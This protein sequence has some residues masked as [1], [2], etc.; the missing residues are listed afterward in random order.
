MCKINRRL[1]FLTAIVNKSLCVIVA[2]HYYFTNTLKAKQSLYR[3]NCYNSLL[4]IFIKMS[5]NLRNSFLGAP[6]LE[7]KQ[8]RRRPA[9]PRKEG[10]KPD[11]RLLCIINLPFYKYWRRRSL[12]EG[13]LFFGYPERA[14]EN[15]IWSCLRR[16]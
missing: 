1:F 5:V 16:Q 13:A 15:F 8:W 2:I 6:F 9:G 3:Y 14:G 7:W 4:Y 10:R 12:L 11:G